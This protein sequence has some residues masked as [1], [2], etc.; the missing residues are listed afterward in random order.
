[1]QLV[2][3]D[4][5]HNIWDLKHFHESK[6]TE[7]TSDEVSGVSGDHSVHED[8]GGGVS[9]V[10]EDDTNPRVI[11][12]ETT[13][14]Q[15]YINI[16]QKRLKHFFNNKHTIRFVKDKSFIGK[17]ELPSDKKLYTFLFRNQMLSLKKDYLRTLKKICF[18]LSKTQRKMISKSAINRFKYI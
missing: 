17:L 10:H 16:Y 13:N 12:P 18:P 8:S 2:Q 3:N 11:T 4:N 6:K 14:K 9:V 5:D 7:D 15:S 1:M